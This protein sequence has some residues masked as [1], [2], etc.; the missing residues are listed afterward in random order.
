MVCYGVAY[1]ASII[2]AVSGSTITIG[3]NAPR[4]MNRAALCVNFT[5]SAREYLS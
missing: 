5:P 4:A 2:H 3:A 1:A